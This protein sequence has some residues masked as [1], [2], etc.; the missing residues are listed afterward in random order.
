VDQVHREALAGGDVDGIYENADGR[1]RA[2]YTKERFAEFAER[3]GDLFVRDNL[4]ARSVETL[5]VDGETFVVALVAV[6]GWLGGREVG[7]YCRA[8]PDGK[9]QLLGIRPDLEAAVPAALQQVLSRM[10]QESHNSDD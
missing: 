10:I 2:Q 6:G 9:L 7:F 5:T 3:H 4:R 1:L 8:A